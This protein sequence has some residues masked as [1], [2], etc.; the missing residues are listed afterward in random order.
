M[1]L[2]ELVEHDHAD[3][4]EVRV[5]HQLPAEDALRDE[6]EDASTRRPADSKRTR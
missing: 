1:A 3:L 5:A 2:V 4:L 6:P